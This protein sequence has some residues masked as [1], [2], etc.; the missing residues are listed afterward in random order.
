MGAGYLWQS[1]NNVMTSMS[2]GNVIHG[3][4]G[5][6]AYQGIVGMAYDTGIKGLQV[7]TEYRMIG[8][9]G[10]FYDSPFYYGSKGGHA[11][12]DD[13]WNHQKAL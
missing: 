5:G 11:S 9:P 2:S 13:R 1:Y 4:S 10:S 3:T 8:Q 6:F 12:F 7:T